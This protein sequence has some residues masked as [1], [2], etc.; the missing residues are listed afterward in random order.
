MVFRVKYE[1]MKYSYLSMKID[2][3]Q[4]LE[5]VAIGYNGCWYYNSDQ[6]L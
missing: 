1:I 2:I 4:I 5:V 6:N 3:T